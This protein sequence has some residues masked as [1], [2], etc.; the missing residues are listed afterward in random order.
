MGIHTS[1]MYQR[2]ADPWAGSIEALMGIAL[3]RALL[4]RQEA[5]RLAGTGGDDLQLGRAVGEA[6]AW[7]D[8]AHLLADLLRERREGGRR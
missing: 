5:E 1:S 4:A 3:T 7:Q 8:A 6:A 2:P